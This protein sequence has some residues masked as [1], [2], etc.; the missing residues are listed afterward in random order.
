MRFARLSDF[1]LTLRFRLVLWVTVVV[2]VLVTLSM[3]VIGQVVRRSLLA[4]FYALLR[5][6]MFELKQMLREHQPP[7]LFD[8]LELWVAEEEDVYFVQMASPTGEPIWQSRATPPLPPLAPPTVPDQLE[9]LEAEKVFYAQSRDPASGWLL[10]VGVARVNLDSDIRL[11]DRVMILASVVIFILTPLAGLFLAGRATRPLQRII[12]TTARLQP[13]RLDERLPV[14]GGGD[15]LDQLSTTIN[16]MLDRIA[17]YIEQDRD[18]IAS[19][20]HEL[21]SPLAAI[22]TSVEVALNRPRSNEEYADLLGGVVEECARLGALVDR[23]LLLAE[24]DA[25]KIEAAQHTTR[26]DK[27]LRE[28]VDMFQGVAEAKDVKLELKGHGAALVRG[29]EYHV[30]Q[31]VRNLIDNALKFTEPPGGVRV[32]WE[33][34]PQRKRAVFRVI[35]QGCGIPAGELCRIFDRFYR[36]DRSRQWRDGHK[37]IGLGLS[38]CQTIVQSLQGEIRV[39]SEAGKG[40]TFAVELPLAEN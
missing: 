29:D 20:A 4:E 34:A 26:L 27:I 22:R 24:G 12:S 23:L 37:G 11:L 2:L 31:I 7:A 28:S 36:V 5:K 33:A 17:S 39:A 21:R 25:G 9:Y 32:E 13:Q 16:G 18:F 14:G 1:F 15:E 8:K 6:D 40:T 10:R 19:A 35:D 38:I 3:I 30:R